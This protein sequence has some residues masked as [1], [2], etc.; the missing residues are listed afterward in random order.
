MTGNTPQQN[1]SH[2]SQFNLPHSQGASQNIPI[3]NSTIVH[4]TVPFLDQPQLIAAIPVQSFPTAPDFVVAAQNQI[5][6]HLQRKHEEL[7]KLIIEQQNELRRVSEQLFIARYGIIPSVVNVTVPQLVGTV[8]RSDITENIRCVSSSATYQENP[9]SQQ[10]ESHNQYVQ[11]DDFEL[12]PFQMTQFSSS[13]ND[14]DSNIS[15]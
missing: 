1:H 2:F 3:L 6:D 4:R 12:I 7:Q 8:S 15:K 5:Q 11:S 14:K 13:H 9:L 10:L